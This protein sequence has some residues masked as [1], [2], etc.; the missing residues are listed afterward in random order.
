MILRRIFS[1][2][3]RPAAPVVAV[4]RLHG[5]I[6]RAG[7]LRSGLTLRNLAGPMER[8]FSLSHLKAVA[9]SIN[10]PGG[11]PVQSALIHARLR[12]LAEKRNVPV[13]VFTE[14][15]AASGGYWLACAG[16]EIYADE[17]SIIGS[18]GVISAGFGFSEAIK[19][20]GIERRVHTSGK[21]K[22]MLDPFQPED[23]DDV[24][25]LKE[26]QAD[27]H[28]NFK[29][30]VRAR[31]GKRLKGDEAEIFSGAF[32]TGKRALEMGLIDAIGDLRTVVRDRFG[33]KVR[34]RV[35]EASRGRLRRRF[36]LARGGD[37]TGSLDWAAGAIAAVE[38]RLIWN[39]FG[40]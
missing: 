19:R 8:A 2:L 3:L 23:Q 33:D 1:F 35:I 7:P 36:G 37:E 11:S 10:S 32:W 40:L 17:N 5:V 31:R 30:L 26:I 27:I 29:T 18:I 38:E 28:E 12:A 25:R 22:G 16:D 6:G 4:L 20:V 14:D 39:R 24:A 21:N 9:V 15:V 13:L 34:L